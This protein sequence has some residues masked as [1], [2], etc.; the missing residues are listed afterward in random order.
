MKIGYACIPLTIKAT[1]NRKLLLKNY[2]ENKL[3]NLIKENLTD[4][5]LILQKNNLHNINLFRIS[6][7]IIPLGSHPINTFNWQNYFKSFLLDIGDYIKLNNMRISM[8]ADHF[9]VLNSKD[10]TVVEK[11]INDLNYLCDFLN[12]LGLDYSHKIILHVGGLY[13][14]KISAKKRFIENFKYLK[15]DLKNRIVIENDEKSFSIYDILEISNILN[16]PVVYDNLHN[17]CHGD[18]SLSHK[19][20]YRMVIK[21]WKNIDGNM[22]V[23]YSQ[24]DLKKAKGSHSKTIFIDDFL[25][26]YNEIKDFNPDIM[27]EVK[28]KDISAIKCIN[29]LKELSNTLNN[30]EILNEFEK[31]LLLILEHTCSLDIS[32]FKNETSIINLYKNIDSYL[33][34]GINN[35]GYKTALN[36]CIKK[37][38]PYISNREYSHFNNILKDVN[39]LEKA[40]IYI[41]KLA[42]KYN[43]LDIIDSYYL[44]Q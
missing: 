17:L 25:E 10:I 6:A 37:L 4:L 35:S 32:S 16:I 39:N 28:D 36:I 24:Q 19:E 11:S 29:S 43:V 26:Y 8:H 34:C 21:T 14:D 41:G 23:H 40:K 18:N 13:G 27:L 5:K 31:Y 44:S 20:I 33:K 38:M 12:S 3:E 7:N 15:E 22:K 30:N 2:D 9:T 42:N 1:N